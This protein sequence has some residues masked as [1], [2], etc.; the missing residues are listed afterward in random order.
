MQ[1]KTETYNTNDDSCKEQL[2]TLY[3]SIAMPLAIISKDLTYIYF[4]E[5][6]KNL[7]IKY[8]YTETKHFLNTFSRIL[9]PEELADIYRCMKNKNRNYSWSGTLE[10]KARDIHAS[11]T[12]MQIMP[13]LFSKETRE[14]QSWIVILD[15]FT[16]EMQGF[17]YVMFKGLLDASK[18]KDNDTGKHIERV[19][20]YA[21]VLAKALYDENLDIL[22]D[23]DFVDNIG[24]LAAMHDV[25]KIGTPD[26]ILNKKGSL[27]DFE[28]KIMKEHT[29][30]G[31]FILSAYPNPM[32]KEIAQSHHERWDG[33]GYPYNLEKDM[34][35]L[36]A[37]I[38]AIADVY[39]A[40]RMK[41]SYKEPKNHK[42]TYD[43]IMRG[44][45]THF[46]PSLVLVFRKHHKEFEKIYDDNADTD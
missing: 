32:A 39:D 7:L 6:Y 29:I 36:S 44:S 35:P 20:L 41:R 12:K 26:D 30:N 28:W 11:I 45:G 14:P 23:V 34:I 5:L 42:E 37:R 18:L 40:L 2:V 13:Y 27:T 4:N 22:V 1:Q 38:V 9:K 17:V 10:H 33:T 43:V 15:D 31:A 46:D 3:K 25:G 8:Q 21:T 19:N 24:F 16:V